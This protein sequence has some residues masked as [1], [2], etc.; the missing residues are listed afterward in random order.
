MAGSLPSFPARR[1]FQTLKA[2]SEL[3]WL[4]M[5]ALA[6]VIVIYLSLSDWQQVRIANE[7]A[8]VS[9]EALRQLS[10]LQAIMLDAE[11]SQR[12]YLLT[13]SE[14]YLR[15]YQEAKRR[16]PSLL[17]GVHSLTGYSANQKT[18]LNKLDDLIGR[19]LDEMRETISLRRE[20]KQ[21][22]ALL[23][24][25]TDEGKVL[26]DQ[27][28]EAVQALTAK[29]LQRHAESRRAVEHLAAV[30]GATSSVAVLLGLLLLTVAVWRIQKEKTAVLEATQAK[31]QFLANMSHELR[32]PLNAIIGYSEMLQEEAED[33]GRTDFLPDLGRIRVAGKHL[34][35]LINSVLDLSKIEAGR[36]DLYLE[37]FSVRDLAAEAESV[38]KPLADKNGNRVTIDC[39]TDIGDMHSDKTKLRQALFNLLSNAAKF[40]EKGEITLRVRREPGN[41]DSIVFAVSDTGVGISREKLAHIFEPFTQGDASTTRR[42]GGTGLGLAISR[43]FCELMG[44]NIWAESIEGVGSTFTMRLSASIGKSERSPATPGTIVAPACQTVVLTIDDDASVHDLLRRTLERHGFRV[45]SAFSGE[46]GLEMAHKLR[47]DAITLDVLMHGMDGWGVLNALKADREMSRIPVIMM[48]VLDNRNQGFLLGATEYLS[49]PVDRARLV[50]VLSRYR[51]HG[52]PCGALVVEDDVDSR[53]LL[54]T[55]LK[56]EGWAVEEAENGRVALECIQRARPYIIL[57]D[58]MMPEMDGFELVARLRESS[59]YRNIPIVVLTAKELTPEDRKRLNGQVAKIVQK[60]AMTVDDVLRDLGSLISHHVRDVPQMSESPGGKG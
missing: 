23:V 4:I 34:L 39:S 47:P 14:Y 57:L 6:L 37:S 17:A 45:E 20:G 21:S 27:I 22:D 60:G 56:S 31:T 8:K 10:D 58:L 38:V 9:D 24:V 28:R 36:M 41:P 42:F 3:P 52:T 55:A 19:K 43:R 7:Q 59:E 46:E 35:Q 25:R 12:G 13:G 44:G 51:R 26:M 40:T 18:H 2:S 32:T 11:A 30:A 5:C 29:E 33:A 49:K 15:P 54:C 1:L 16:V 53:H 50:E 48:T